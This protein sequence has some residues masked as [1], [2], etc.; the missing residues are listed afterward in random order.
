M[1]ALSS[2]CEPPPP[3][4]PPPLSTT[5]AS[6]KKKKTKRRR[7]RRKTVDEHECVDDTATVEESEPGQTSTAPSHG[8]KHQEK[9]LHRLGVSAERLKAAGVQPKDYYRLA[10]Q[11]C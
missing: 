3:P 1:I 5:F 6:T 4:P 11:G 10:S 8:Q 9:R 7:K 2:F